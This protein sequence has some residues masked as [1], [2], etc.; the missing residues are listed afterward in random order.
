[1]SNEAITK[2]VVAIR[3]P[4]KQGVRRS[5]IRETWGKDFL[6]LGFEVFFVV[7]GDPK[8]TKPKLKKDLLYT[9][10]TY[11]PG[12]DTHR[13]LTNRMCWLWRYLKKCSY[14]HVLVIDDDCSVN[15]PIFMSLD[16]DKADA[17]GHNNGGFL[18]GS[19]AVYSK[20]VV[21]KLD[22][23]MPKDDVVIGAVLSHLK[24]KLT[25]AGYPCPVK[26]WPS[27]NK[28]WKFGDPTV[29][30]SHYVRET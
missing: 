28:K 20:H 6:E 25:H 26:P 9:P 12:T 8:I 18:S 19:A 30:I 16:W 11:T 29:A 15:V 23:H 14:T 17:W 13:D 10:G 2:L 5:A 1:M 22:Y 21:E 7:S 4:L 3:S 27:K 24:I